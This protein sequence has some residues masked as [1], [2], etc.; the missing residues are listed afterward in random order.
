MPGPTRTTLANRRRK[1]SK[2]V[3]V[4]EIQTSTRDQVQRVEKRHGEAASQQ[5]A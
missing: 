4:Q 2:S 1:K 5:H 3:R